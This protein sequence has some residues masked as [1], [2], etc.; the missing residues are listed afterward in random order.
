MQ[1][2]YHITHSL[3][4]LA[5]GLELLLLL[6]PATLPL[7]KISP[8]VDPRIS[9]S[10]PV[11]IMLPLPLPLL[12]LLIL[13]ALFPALLL[14]LRFHLPPPSVLVVN[15]NLP[16]LVTPLLGKFI[17][18]QLRGVDCPFILADK[19]HAGVG[20]GFVQALTVLLI[21][22]LSLSLL[23]PVEGIWSLRILCFIGMDEERFL[24]ISDL[25]VG[26]WNAW[27]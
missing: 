20:N 11:L 7:L 26:F 21:H 3:Y 18:L 5:D 16:R 17:C 9:R 27:L 23:Q 24:A 14:H 13:L 12:E 2:R 22:Q 25:D 15:E 6:R 4:P 10:L 19:E 8:A 1:S